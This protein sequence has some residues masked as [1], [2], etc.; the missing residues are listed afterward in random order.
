MYHMKTNKITSVLSA[1]AS[2]QAT[3]QLLPSFIT[4]SPQARPC[5]MSHMNDWVKAEHCKFLTGLRKYSPFF[6]EMIKQYVC[7][8][9]ITDVMRHTQLYYL[10]Q[11]TTN[12]MKC[13]IFN[14]TLDL[15]QMFQIA[16]DLRSGCTKN[17]STL[18]VA[19]LL[20]IVVTAEEENQ[21]IW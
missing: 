20:R 16:K 14:L 2:E 18:T 9:T 1:Q 11:R 10:R 5:V 19:A 12:K 21:T 8:G 13:F 7:K 6:R 17:I 3:G 15:P 4:P